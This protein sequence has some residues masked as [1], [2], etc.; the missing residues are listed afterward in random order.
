MSPQTELEDKITE[1][2]N[3]LV[4]NGTQPRTPPAFLPKDDYTFVVQTKAS[5]DIDESLI[6]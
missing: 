5:K 1:T 3:Y 2:Q 4:R 6:K